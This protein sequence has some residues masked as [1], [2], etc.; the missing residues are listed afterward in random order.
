MKSRFAKRLALGFIALFLLNVMAQPKPVAQLILSDLIFPAAQAWD[1]EWTDAES[2]RTGL[3]EDPGSTHGQAGTDPPQKYYTPA[4]RDYADV[5]PEELNDYFQRWDKDYSPYALAR[6]TQD[7]HYRQFVLPKGY[8]L[9][10]PGDIQDGS[11]HVKLKDLEPAIAESQPLPEVEDEDAAKL[12]GKKQS[13]KKPSKKSNETTLHHS[14][15][16]VLVIKRQGKVIV[17]VP[18]HRRQFY[19]PAYHDKIPNHALAWV[20]E[21]DRHPVLKFYF[22]NWLY[23]TDFQ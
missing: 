12:T 5:D 18:I 23:A 16:Q 11:P 14:A 17:V 7:L 6:I 3:F 10:K 22:H 13:P 2:G 15:Y 9:I 20:E 8:Y 1:G 21:E 19:R 4:P